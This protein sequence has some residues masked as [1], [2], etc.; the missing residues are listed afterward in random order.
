[1]TIAQ[2]LIKHQ[3]IKA[4]LTIDYIRS[5]FQTKHFNISNPDITDLSRTDLSKTDLSKTDLSKTDPDN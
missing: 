1:M 2:I 3:K 5:F 4:D